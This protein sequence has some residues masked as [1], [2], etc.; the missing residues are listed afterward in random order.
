L[1]DWTTFT[2]TRSVLIHSA[3]LV[4]W[5]SAEKTKPNIEEA[6]TVQKVTKLVQNIQELWLN[7]KKPKTTSAATVNCTNYSCVRV[8]ACTTVVENTAQNSCDN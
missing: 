1:D 7:K 6:N 2:P 4:S 5:L 8:C 3:R